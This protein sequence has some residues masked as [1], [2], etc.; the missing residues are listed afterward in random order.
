[1]LP[2][3]LDNSPE[4]IVGAVARAAEGRTTVPELP[5]SLEQGTGDFHRPIFVPW[6]EGNRAA[7]IRL[8]YNASEDAEWWT[9]TMKALLLGMLL[10]LP[11][12]SVRLRFVD[13]NLSGHAS[14]FTMN[15]PPE[16][17]HGEVVS[18][19]AD[20]RSMVADLQKHIASVSAKCANV[21]SYNRSKGEILTPY[22]VV[23]LLDFPKNITAQHVKALQPLLENGY[24]A[25]V[26][27]VM[28]DNREA[29]AERGVEELLGD[30][31]FH[32]TQI[33]ED[34]DSLEYPFI[35][36]AGNGE[37]NAAFFRYLRE[38]YKET[39]RTKVI[40]VDSQTL[41]REPYADASE[42]VLSIEVGRDGGQTV[43]FVLNQEDHV[44]AFVIGKS[45]SGKSVFLR[46]I[47]L[48]ATMKYA[49]EDLSLYLIDLKVGGVEFNG[50]QALLHTKAAL[51]DDSDRQIVLEILRDI[52]AEIKRRGEV[53][54][55]AESSKIQD[56]N[57]SHS[58][59]RMSQI[60][61]VVDECQRLFDESRRDRIQSEI[62]D[63]VD[64]IATQGRAFGVHLLLSTQ[65]LRGSMVSSKVK[66]NVSDFYLLKGGMADG[67]E[68]LADQTASLATGQVLY[69]DH[70]NNRLF[71]AYFLSGD[72]KGAIIE[73]AARKAE[74]HRDNGRFVFMGKMVH[75]FGKE[76]LDA[77]RKVARRSPA[78]AVG[79]AV[80]L[81]LSPVAIPLKD[82]MSENV[83]VVG[84]DAR[85]AADM[86]Q[87]TYLSVMAS[88][89]AVGRACRFLCID[90]LD[91][92][93]LPYYDLA[94]RLA[95]FG[96]ELVP[97][98]SRG[99]VISE[100]AGQL[101]SGTAE[102]TVVLILGQE[103]FTQLL[104]GA[105]IK[106]ADEPAPVEQPKPAG[107]P[108]FL[109]GIPPGGLR[110]GAA[111]T[112]TFRSELQYLLENGPEQGVHFIWQVDRLPNLLGDSGLSKQSILRMFRHLVI[113][114]SPADSVLRLGL[115][116]ELDPERLNTDPERL[117]AYY[118]NLLDARNWLLTPYATT[119]EEELKTLL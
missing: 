62:S 36:L 27:F 112:P 56:Y 76:D 91:D 118:I 116:A 17:Y 110:S 115:P 38:G 75:H 78:F 33:R 31:S 82:D 98:R 63:I 35:P 6:H 45:G 111:K 107:T 22:E 10:S 90:C 34:R 68:R 46:D 4:E 15:L 5:L 3:D 19:E 81:D 71:Q 92:P 93:E 26:S 12:G 24:K 114:R 99:K 106:Q 89:N 119:T 40:A 104:V 100:L 88:E 65:T 25:G 30:P 95:D 16:L 117:R 41:A 74:G 86:A 61:V 55:A 105:E 49:P 28:M 44:H 37:R 29:E 48:G 8:V 54:R 66:E 11:P 20:F 21:I 77:L 72:Q 23:V 14:F 84:S 79:R 2:M 102:P 51:L 70:R 39:T 94:D 53:M 42:G 59:E 52:R 50:Y 18:S 64:E 97:S 7:N 43:D 13:L 67:L 73:E 101:R 113:L 83:L 87:Q 96:S 60:L 32:T 80:S 108:S 47:I 69:A 58:Q 9:G 57:R 109:Q 103:R 85:T 1:M